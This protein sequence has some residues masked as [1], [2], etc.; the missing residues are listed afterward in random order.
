[1]ISTNYAGVGSLYFYA[2]T[3]GTYNI[4]VTPPFDAT[5]PINTLQAT[6]MYRATYAT[7]ML[8]VGVMTNPTDASTFVAIDTVY[9]STSSVTTW[10]EQEVVFSQYTGTGQYIAFKNAYTSTYCYAYIDNLSIDLIPSCPKPQSLHANTVTT[11][12]ID[13]GWTE[14]GS[15]TSWEIAYGAPGFSPSGTTATVVTATTNPFT[16]T[17]LNSTTTY[18][19]YVRSLCGGTDVS[20]WS[21]ALQAST[22][23]TPEP[24]PYTADFS[25]NDAWVLNNGSCTNYWMKGTS[26]GTP[27]L[28]VTNNGSTPNYDGTV[29]S[30]VA[31][32]KLFTVGTADTITVSFNIMVDGESSFDY[33]KLFLAPP[34]QQFPAATSVASDHFGYN[35][36]STNAYNF[37]ANGYGT[38]SSYP[39]ILNKLTSTIQVTAKMLN[40]IAN[41][42]ANSTA[43]LALTWKNDGSVTYNPPAT[44][45]NLTVTASNAAPVTCPTPTNV[46]ASN[47]TQTSATITWTAGG[48]ET[49]WELQYKTAAASSWSNSINVTGT[50]SHNLTGLTAGTQYQVRVRA[51]CGTTETSNWS[52][53]ASFTTTQASVTPPTVTTNDATNI[54]TTTATL[55]GAVTAGS[56]TITAQGFEWKTTTGGTYTQVSATGNTM[57]YNLTGLTPNTSYTFKAFATTASGTTY[58]AEKTFTTTVETCPAPTNVAASN[59]TETTAD[60]SWTQP[61]NAATSWDVLYKESGADSWFTATTTSNPYTLTGLTGASSYDVQVIAHCTNGMTSEP[62]ATITFMTVGIDDYVLDNSVTV[63][64]NPTNG[65]VQIQSSDIMESLEIY[66]TY[67]KL[68]GTETV[69]SN[70]A[71]VDLTGYAKGTYFVR[72]TTERGVVTKR[73]VKM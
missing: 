38:Q 30:A 58:G 52:A 8:I 31:A 65:K 41:P 34:T 5:I 10:I 37:Y 1:V 48:S 73:V 53:T 43:L 66:D 68:I 6:F 71:N 44:I 64:P 21:N 26:S 61:D 63:Y 14:V 12:S 35:S 24:L 11:N 32:L 42:D 47:I 25:T 51:V 70:E 40:P 20:N 33:F 46:A 9:P 56:E 54:T 18:E 4:A 49:A 69:N 72:V 27:A 29:A 45:T 67:G 7:D 23:M 22:T 39:Y 2:G 17:G 50:P 28:F 15:A 60:I 57:S 19:F 13:L 3:S 59:I 62:S 16:I 36:Y 55:N